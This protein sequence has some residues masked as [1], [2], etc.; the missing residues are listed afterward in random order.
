MYGTIP[1][2]AAFSRQGVQ[3]DYLA[4]FMMSS[5]LLNP[6][7]MIYS[8]ALGEAALLIRFLSCFLCGVTA[9]GL[10]RIFYQGKSFFRF[11]GV[12]QLSYRDTDPNLF[13]RLL[14]TSAATCVLRDCGSSLAFCS[15]HSTSATFPRIGRPDCSGVTTALA[16]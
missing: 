15:R 7:L 4:A 13:V 6:Q 1:L 11:E 9:G 10:I 14:K 16:C 5:V 8:A 12:A 3:D 2:A